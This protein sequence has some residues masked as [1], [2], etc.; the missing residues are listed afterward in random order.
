LSTELSSHHIT[1]HTQQGFFS[2]IAGAVYG[3]LPSENF[4][5][6]MQFSP[7]S[8]FTS[9]FFIP[10]YR[11]NH[12]IF[13][14]FIGHGPLPQAVKKSPARLC[15][16]AIHSQINATNSILPAQMDML[17]EGLLIIKS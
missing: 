3:R 1:T 7:K 10:L 4:F 5:K 11:K 17:I 6:I 15:E 12:A 14:K 13:P 16:R 2:S 9:G 8:N